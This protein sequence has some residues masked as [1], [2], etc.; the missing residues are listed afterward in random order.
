[1]SFSPTHS[2]ATKN[3]AWLTQPS[4]VLEIVK[5]LNFSCAFLL[6]TYNFWF[7]EYIPI[8]CARRAMILCIK[9]AMIHTQFLEW[10]VFWDG[11]SSYILAQSLK[12]ESCIRQVHV[13]LFT[14]WLICDGKV[15]AGVVRQDGTIF[16]A[17]DSG[18]YYLN[19]IS[20]HSCLAVALMTFLGYW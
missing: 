14:F 3:V 9:W 8:F 20:F 13:I 6:Q 19:L 5:L 1:M 11:G 2:W 17:T 7:C 4:A 12:L 15:P 16:Q 10:L 18:S